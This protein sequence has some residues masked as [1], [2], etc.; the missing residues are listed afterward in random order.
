MS[1]LTNM[2]IEH[3]LLFF[4]YHVSIILSMPIYILD[5]IWNNINP[6]FPKYISNMFEDN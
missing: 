4:Q 3:K 6:V 1:N 2:A 5:Y